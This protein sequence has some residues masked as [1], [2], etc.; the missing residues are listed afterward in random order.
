MIM[1]IIAIVVIAIVICGIFRLNKFPKNIR[2]VIVWKDGRVTTTYNTFDSF[3]D[4]EEWMD[5]TYR[6]PNG[7]LIQ[8][9]TYTYL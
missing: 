3:Q 6:G 2:G 7:R 4:F 8:K 9:I 5:Y 1:I